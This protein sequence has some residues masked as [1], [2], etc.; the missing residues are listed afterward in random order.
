MYRVNACPDGNLK[1]NSPKQRILY[2]VYTWPEDHV[3]S[4]HLS[5]GRTSASGHRV[6][7]GQEGEGKRLYILT[8][9]SQEV[10]G[11]WICYL[12]INKRW[13]I[14][15]PT[16][17]TLYDPSYKDINHPSPLS[18]SSLASR[19]RGSSVENSS[20]Q[21]IIYRVCI[22]QSCGSFTRVWIL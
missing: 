5:T 16:H 12:H 7:G 19:S 10:M 22:Y 17:K 18:V 6:G 2:R 21:R 8:V 14:L 1:S 11:Y 9:R 15:P 3:Q 4:I 13:D 20:D